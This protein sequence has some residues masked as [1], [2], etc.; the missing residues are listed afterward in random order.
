MAP[1]WEL[2][3]QPKRR[4]KKSLYP[5][6]ALK[7]HT[8]KIRKQSLEKEVYISPNNRSNGKIRFQDIVSRLLGAWQRHRVAVNN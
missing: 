8:N 4:L 5:S 7:H 6:F 2:H 1:V 3:L